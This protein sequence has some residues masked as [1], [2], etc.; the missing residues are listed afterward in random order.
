MMCFIHSRSQVL[1]SVSEFWVINQLTTRD[2]Y[3]SCA[4][5]Y[6]R[7]VAAKTADRKPT[8]DR[9]DD[10]LKKRLKSSKILTYF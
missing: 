8:A 3:G 10:V 4:R 7:R 9:D 2:L 6:N 5:L 1:T